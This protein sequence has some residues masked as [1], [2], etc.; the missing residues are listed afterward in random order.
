MERIPAPAPVMEWLNKPSKGGK[1]II[2]KLVPA[3]S[4]VL[5]SGL[6][7]QGFKTWLAYWLATMSA[8]GVGYESSLGGS[9]RKPPRPVKVLVF[10]EEGSLI[11][12]KERL[13]KVALGLGVPLNAVRKLL[14]LPEGMEEN[15]EDRPYDWVTEALEPDHPYF[16]NLLVE[17]DCGI[18]LDVRK[19]IDHL[20]AL[21]RE[22]KADLVIFDAL[23]YMFNGSEND[24]ETMAV[25]VDGLKAIR[26]EGATVMYLVHLR[27]DDD[28]SDI[29]KVLRGHTILRD[30]YDLHLASRRP[31]D[32]DSIHLHARYRDGRRRKFE[33]F[34]RIPD[35]GVMGPVVL[36][37]KDITEDTKSK[38]A[39]KDGPIEELFRAG[40][41]RNVAYGASKF[42][43]DLKLSEGNAAEIR[44]MLINL[45][46]LEQSPDGKTVVLK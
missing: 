3:G 12:M 18:K 26:S 16:K 46:K 38:V 7:K 34:W 42:A 43:R 19:S 37:L 24:K 22:H 39:A 6:P 9:W 36:D 15:D 31:K 35:E 45:G 17:H 32:G 10:Q 40:W 4:L 11:A 21:T 30:S 13:N 2:P 14:P 5:V 23:T 8:A 33:L 41:V 29:D 1:W 20:V 44:G 25:V 27:K 28:D